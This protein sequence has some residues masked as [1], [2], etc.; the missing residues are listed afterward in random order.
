VAVV[1]RPKPLGCHFKHLEL[2]GLHGRLV[3]IVLVL[4]GARIRQHLGQFDRSVTQA[5]LTTASAQLNSLYG[6][7][8]RPEIEADRTELSWL[9]QQVTA[10]VLKMMQTEDE[11][12]YDEPIFD[13]LHLIAG[14]PGFAPADRLQGLMEVVEHGSLLRYITPRLKGQRVVVVIGG[15]N[16][17]SAMRDCSVVMSQYGLPDEVRG[18]VG[19]VGPTRMPYA[20]TI[21]VVGYLSLILSQLVAELYG[22]KY[23]GEGDG[24]FQG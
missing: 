9:E 18:A 21:P 15:E 19:V 22:R 4:H 13:G 7:M 16:E 1:T 14:Q 5:A 24:I 23:E 8:G 10:F 11:Q 20:R 12:Q 3:L 2:A 6:D 17:E